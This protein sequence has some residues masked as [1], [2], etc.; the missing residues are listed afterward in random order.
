MCSILGLEFHRGLP[1]DSIIGGRCGLFPGVG[2]AEDRGAYG[3]GEPTREDMFEDAAR[4]FWGKLLLPM[5]PR[6]ILLT[7]REL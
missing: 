5:D 4:V 1:S 2:V 6:G 7:L 3:D